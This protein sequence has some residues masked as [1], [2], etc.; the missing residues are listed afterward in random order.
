VFAPQFFPRFH[1]GTLLPLFLF[2]RVC[3]VAKSAY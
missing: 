2:R 3:I 1:A